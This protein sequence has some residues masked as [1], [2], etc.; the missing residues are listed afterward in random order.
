MKKY[1]VIT[2]ALLICSVLYAQD[3]VYPSK[4]YKG[5]LFI[6]NGTIHVGNGQIIENGT[7]KIN[8][9]KIEQVG[10]KLPVP[11]DNVKVVDAKGAQIYPGLI[12]PVTDLGLKEIAL[13]VRGTNDFQE[14]GDMN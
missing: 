9:G 2:T 11:A 10:Q 1:L 8:N 14:I 6:T 12:L 7:I 4:D 13:S 3:D 5:L